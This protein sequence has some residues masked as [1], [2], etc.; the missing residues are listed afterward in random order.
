MGTVVGIW[1]LKM[2]IFLF[3]LLTSIYTANAYFGS[4]T[5]ETV[6][7]SPFEENIVLSENDTTEGLDKGQSLIDVVFGI[8]DF[9]TFGNIDNFYARLLINVFIS[10]CWIGIG[11]IMYT[12]VK[13]W[14]PFT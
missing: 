2:I 13:E 5:I 9:L 8:G 14:I 1:R 10:I 4:I 12:F 6:D 3:I 11:Y 7:Y